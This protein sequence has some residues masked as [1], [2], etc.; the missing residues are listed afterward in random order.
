MSKPPFA[1][2]LPPLLLLTGCGSHTPPPE[3]KE[4]TVAPAQSGDVAIRPDS[5]QLQQIKIATVET[6]EVPVDVVTAPGRIELNPNRVAHVV[7]PLAGRIV[8]VLVKLGD[9]VKKGDPV[10]QFESPDADVAVSAYLSAVAAVNTAKAALIKAQADLDR[11]RDLYEH[12]AVAQKE[13]LNA[14]SAVQQAKAAVDQTEAAREQTQRRLDLLGLKNNQ[15]GQKITISAPTSGKVLELS[16]AAGEY[17][18]DTNAP[19]M[20]IADL[21]S[22]W[23]ASDVPE[24]QIR[25]IELGERLDIELA[26]FPG[27][28]FHGRVTRLGDTVDPQTRTL[29]VRAE[30]DNSRGLLRPEMFGNIRHV[31]ST[32]VRPVIPPGAVVQSDGQT[33]VYR[34][35][36]KGDFEPVK[37]T[38]GS[39]LDGRVAVTSGVK[40]GDRIV[41]DGV[42]LLKAS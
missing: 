36:S 22:V 17:R 38:L 8:V 11:T 7:L 31:D 15:F 1:V 39:Q 19:L 41:V 9:S 34:E 23:V 32:A 3:K 21:S 10:L 37:V 40:A 28:L 2:F 42:M 30:M 12:Q 20:T 13:V 29:K 16:V 6:A 14:Q 27:Q 5:A 33:I 26:A 24:T 18:N 4:T 25:F 35:R